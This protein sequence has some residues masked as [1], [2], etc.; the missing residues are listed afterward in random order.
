MSLRLIY[1]SL[2]FISFSEGSAQVS[3]EHKYS[4][5]G[6]ERDSAGCLLIYDELNQSYS[7]GSY[8]FK[9]ITTSEASSYRPKYQLQNGQ[10][11]HNKGDIY[12]LYDLSFE[13]SDFYEIEDRVYLAGNKGLWIFKEGVVKKYY[14]PGI[15]FPKD[16]HKVKAYDQYVGMISRDKELY[17][18]DTLH[19][20]IKFIDNRVEDFSIDKWHSVFYSRG[21]TLFLYTA[22]VNDLT[23]AISSIVLRDSNQELLSSPYR[24]SPGE[25][26]EVHFETTY[27][28]KMNAIDCQYSLNG[29]PW[30]ATTS[31]NSVYLNLK[32]AGE[33]ELRL[34]ALGVKDIAATSRPID[35]TV[36]TD[37]LAKFWPWLFGSVCLLLLLNFFSQSRLKN[38][39]KQL[40]AQ[41]ERMQ[42]ELQIAHE[43]QRV[44]Q[45]QMNPH[46]LFNSLNSISGLI[47]LN[48]NQKARTSLNK[49]SQLMRKL[50]DGSIN[51]W[52]TVERELSFLNDYLHLEKMIRNEKF[53]FKIESDVEQTVMIPPMILQPFLENAIIHG[54][55][56]K[57]SKGHLILQL[58]SSGTKVEV[59][60]E[61]DGIGRDA[62]TA[63][64]KEGHESA[65]LKIVEQRLKTLNKWDKMGIVYDDLKDSNG[66]PI[67]TR[68]TLHLPTKKV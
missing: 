39:M 22:M 65:A 18:Y 3:I 9:E 38:E 45:V 47:A 58:R 14:V 50:L 30:T 57:P 63:Y 67:G 17:I 33:Y 54:I 61:D 26:V 13:V 59:T 23:P 35:I 44:G 15:S 32:A 31:P 19:Q 37:G 34:K 68:V 24:V 21:K 40:E 51:E 48:E 5:T 36:A 62:A 52:T 53:D 1:I 64:K 41:K 55:K 27:S 10:L 49:F 46:F 7:L 25:R 60:I 56:N 20:T 42:L 4:I 8:K 6:L 43:Q 28:P 66:D 16:L 29:G 11:R 2:L 12:S